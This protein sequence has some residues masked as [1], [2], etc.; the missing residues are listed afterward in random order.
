MNLRNR[1]TPRLPFRKVIFLYTSSW[2]SVVMQFE[3]IWGAIQK[4]PDCVHNFWTIND[5]AFI[6]HQWHPVYVLNIHYEYKSNCST[7]L[8]IMIAMVTR[9]LVMR[10]KYQVCSWAQ[11]IIFILIHCI[12]RLPWLLSTNFINVL[13]HLMFITSY[14]YQLLLLCIVSS[15]FNAFVVSKANALWTG[16]KIH[17]S[18]FFSKLT[19][20]CPW[21]PWLLDNTVEYL[22]LL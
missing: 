2:C 6:F 10:G 12:T 20:Q 17:S 15:H 18:Q 16:H 14:W 5:N 3:Y 22:V 21:F 9:G 19:W 4:Y 11:E 8:Q 13:T 1:T 7:S